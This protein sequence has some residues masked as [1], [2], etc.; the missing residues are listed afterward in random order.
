MS[1]AAQR[2]HWAELSELG[3]GSHDLHA[4]EHQQP[5]VISKCTRGIGVAVV[6]M[7]ANSSLYSCQRETSR[8]RIPHTYM[9]TIQ[10]ICSL[11]EV[12]LFSEGFPLTGNAICLSLVLLGKSRPTNGYG[13]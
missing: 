7:E 2:D 8:N 4:P 12:Q 3:R 13:I 10:F 9:V 1:L 6:L 5:G 11:R